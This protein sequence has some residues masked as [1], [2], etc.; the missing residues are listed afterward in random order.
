MYRHLTEKLLL[1]NDCFGFVR[2]LAHAG[3]SCA[4]DFAKHE[5]DRNGPSHAADGYGSDRPFACSGVS[6][7]IH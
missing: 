1:F 7:I 5:A 4:L 6:N 3:G 2:M